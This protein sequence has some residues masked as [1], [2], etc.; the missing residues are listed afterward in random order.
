MVHRRRRKIVGVGR[1]SLGAIFTL[2]LRK[3]DATGVGDYK[4]PPT[5]EIVLPPHANAAEAARTVM[6]ALRRG[7]ALEGQPA[8]ISADSVVG[9]W[10]GDRVALIGDYDSSA[11]WRELYETKSYRNISRELVEAWNPFV[12]RADH[13]LTYDPCSSCV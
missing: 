2:L 10:A 3:S 6:D 7:V 13:R 5:Q 11:L 1:Q 8:A 4:S 9:R 12:E